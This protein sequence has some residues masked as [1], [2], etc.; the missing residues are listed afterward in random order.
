MRHA[1]GIVVAGRL[2]SRELARPVRL[3]GIVAAHHGG[4]DD[5]RLVV[6]VVERQFLE[7]GAAVAVEVY[8]RR[9]V[10]AVRD[11]ERVA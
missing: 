6:R 8:L 5:G 7:E 1:I 10:V 9:R 11:E 3:C 4:V 2:R